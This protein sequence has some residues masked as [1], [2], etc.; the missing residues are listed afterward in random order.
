MPAEFAQATRPYLL[1][2]THVLVL[3]APADAQIGGVASDARLSEARLARVL[4][5][6]P[7]QNRGRRNWLAPG[8]AC[9]VEIGPG[10]VIENAA[11]AGAGH[12]LLNQC[13]L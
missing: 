4:A 5:P 12:H 1:S 10:P 11:Q 9:E 2:M 7:V 8:T 13:K 3:I 6:N